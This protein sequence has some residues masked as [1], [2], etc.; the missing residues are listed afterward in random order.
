MKRGDVYWAE[1]TPRSGSEQSGR[2]PVV[3]VS[4]DGFN[5]NS[6]WNSV[7]VVPFTTSESQRGRGAS[8]VLIPA[9]LVGLQKDSVAIC[10][11]VTTLDRSKLSTRICSLPEDLVLEV[12]MG[13]KAALGLD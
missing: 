8:A 10:H 12:D 5:L 7:V 6:R 4:N 1:L 3:I 13:L 11:Q 2:R 9:G